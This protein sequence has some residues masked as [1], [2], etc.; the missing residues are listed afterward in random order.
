QFETLERPDNEP[1]TLIVSIDGDISDVVE[2][3]AAELIKMQAI[4]PI[5]HRIHEQM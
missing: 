2:R 3:S 5:H 4:E 1:Q